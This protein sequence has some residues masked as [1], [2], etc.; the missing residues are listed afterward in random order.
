MGY[1]EKTAARIRKVLATRDDVGERKMFGG[2]CFMVNDRMCVGLTSDALMVR[3]GPDNHEDA[4]AQPHAR[5]MDFTGRVMR[6]FVFVDP[7][8]FATPASL[9]RWVKRGVDFALTTPA[10]RPKRKRRPKFP[11]VAKKRRRLA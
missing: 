4:L 5:P 8:G 3:V 10:P 1:D 2:L 9:A 7:P 11:K 6:G